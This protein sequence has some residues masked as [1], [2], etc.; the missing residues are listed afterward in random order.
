MTDLRTLVELEMERA[1]APSYSFV[2]LARRRDRKQRNKRIGTAA[3]A[4]VL[5]AA[6]ISGAVHAFDRSAGPR[7]IVPPPVSPLPIPPPMHNGPFTLFGYLFGMNQLGPNGEA[8]PRLFKCSGSCTE[9]RGAAWTSDG[10]RVAFIARCGGGCASAGDPYHGIRVYDPAAVT[11]RLVVPGDMFSALA[12]SPDGTR[13]AF[14]VVPS[15]EYAGDLRLRPLSPGGQVYIVNADGSGQRALPGA[16]GRVSSLS[17]SPDGTRILYSS[18]S[19]ASTRPMYVE[20]ID[21]TGLRSLGSGSDAS[22]SPDGTR[23]AFTRVVGCEVWVMS[24]DGTGRTRI[25]N[26]PH[27]K[28]GACDAASD[29]P[30]PVWSPDRKE[31]AVIAGS[32]LYVMNPDGAGDHRAP[33]RERRSLEGRVGLPRFCNLSSGSRR[34]DSGPGGMAERTKATVLKTVRGASPSRVR[35]PVPP[36][37]SDPVAWTERPRGSTIR[38]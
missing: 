23:I 37:G 36:P 10:S 9:I 17:W 19:T 14:A 8:A 25:A 28:P 12:W 20:G 31:L 16:T 27:P 21:G 26:L 22:W 29:F 24:A 3:L 6:A 30:G 2:D 1:G 18:A 4:L 34:V 38:L 35:I 33:E 15:A 13:I 5:A 32:V 11:D 7:P